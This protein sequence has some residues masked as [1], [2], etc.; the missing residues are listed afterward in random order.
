MKTVDSFL[1]KAVIGLVF[2]LVNII[3]I[4]LLL[5]GHNLPGGGFIGG[6]TMGM[7]FIL[8]GL[9]RG[10]TTL[11][12]ELPVPPLRVAAF[13]LLLAILSGIGPMFAGKPF[14]TQYNLHIDALPWVDELHIGT[15]LVFDVG[16]FLLVGF[17]TAKLIIVLARSTSGLLAFTRG[18]ARYYASVL[19]EPIEEPEAREGGE[20]AS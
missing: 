11:Q 17:M 2:L 13:G 1:A 15:P 3:S 10:W 16:V 6:L 7:S 8:L 12:D 20:D 14:L 19:E 18:E 9:I 4:Y 5:R